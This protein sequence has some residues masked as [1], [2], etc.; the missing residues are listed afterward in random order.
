[1]LPACTAWDTRLADDDAVGRARFELMAEHNAGRSGS[2]ERLSPVGVAAWWNVSCAER[3]SSSFERLRM[4]VGNDGP[5]PLR[6]TERVGPGE[7][8]VGDCCNTR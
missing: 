2:R 1:V 3:G 7:R 4:M 6:A 5:R 8:S